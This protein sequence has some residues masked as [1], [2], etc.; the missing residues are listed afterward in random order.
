MS[1]IFPSYIRED[2]QKSARACIAK[3]AQ[4]ERKDEGLDLLHHR[5]GQ[6]I[7]WNG[8]SPDCGFHP[9]LALQMQAGRA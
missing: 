8:K 6:A 2:A 5:G 9:P 4:F 3:L 7:G 1:G